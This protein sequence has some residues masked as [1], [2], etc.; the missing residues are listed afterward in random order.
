MALSAAKIG[1]PAVGENWI[2]FER[3]GG[4]YA[5][6]WMVQAAVDRVLAKVEDYEDRNL[7]VLHALDE[8]HLVCHYCGEAL[9]YNTP[10]RTPGFEFAAVASRVAEVLADDHGIFN[11]I[12]LFNPY[13]ARKVL[14]VYPARAGQQASLHKRVTGDR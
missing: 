2:G 6:A 3:A 12:F 11:R 10:A 7:H 4:A 5:P 1:I 14:Q 8:L 13:E 9:L